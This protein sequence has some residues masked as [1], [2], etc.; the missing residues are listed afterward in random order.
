[1]RCCALL[2]VV[3]GIGIAAVVAR[4]V[5]AVALARTFKRGARGR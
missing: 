3:L 2:V 4:L 5:L 1:M